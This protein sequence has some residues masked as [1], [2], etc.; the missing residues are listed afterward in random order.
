MSVLVQNRKESQAEFINTAHEIEKLTIRLSMRENAIPKRYRY[1]LA[2]PLVCSA[3]AL[4]QYITYAN[5]IF[6]KTQEEYRIRQKYQKRAMLEVK[7]LLE[8]MRLASELLPIKNTVLEEWTR[9]V[10]LE[11]NVLRKWTQA[12]KKRYAELP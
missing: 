12:D 11:E 4:N 5:A 9:K 3:R 8:L 6:P 10:V 2:Q 7:N 1:F